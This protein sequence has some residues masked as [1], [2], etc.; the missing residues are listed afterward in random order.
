MV[1]KIQDDQS[2]KK[3]QDLS[4]EKNQD[5]YHKKNPGLARIKNK[6]T[7]NILDEK[8]ILALFPLKKSSSCSLTSLKQPDW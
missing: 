6:H 7:K 5:I 4:V 8:I 2:G 1:K 3:R